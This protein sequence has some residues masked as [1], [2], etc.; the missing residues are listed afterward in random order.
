MPVLAMA[1]SQY[2]YEWKDEVITVRNISDIDSISFHRTLSLFPECSHQ[3]LQTLRW[4]CA[5]QPQQQNLPLP[6]LQ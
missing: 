1:Q 3:M 6:M 2:F 5:I 4:A